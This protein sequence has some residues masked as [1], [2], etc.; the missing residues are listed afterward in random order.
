[1]I[2]TE[3][4]RETGTTNRPGSPNSHRSN[5]GPPESGLPR[6]TNDTSN[7]S[8]ATKP[9]GITDFLARKHAELQ[10]LLA[11][12]PIIPRLIAICVAYCA[13]VAICIASLIVLF[14]GSFVLTG[15]DRVVARLRWLFELARA[16]RDDGLAGRGLALVWW[17]IRLAG[18]LVTAVATAASGGGNNT[19]PTGSNQHSHSFESKYGQNTRSTNNNTSRDHRR[20]STYSSGGSTPS[21]A[22]SPSPSSA[23]Q[24]H[25]A[26]SRRERARSTSANYKY[27]NGTSTA[28][29]N[30]RR[31]SSQP[32]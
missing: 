29:D 25:T 8:T 32:L 4:T 22:T 6:A 26:N 16:R 30:Y 27:T 15:H 2:N 1:M 10:T 17:L 12:F 9:D 21:T 3:A 19:A 24:D 13:V 20:R 5:N 18:D 23:P 14:V 31:D 7:T 11:R 28:H